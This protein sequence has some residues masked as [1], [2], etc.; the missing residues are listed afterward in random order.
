MK[1]VVL[2][3]GAANPGDLSWSLFERFGEVTAYS[4]TS[5]EVL[6][7]RAKDADICLTNKT[8][9][10]EEVISELPNLKYIGVLA[11]GYNVVDTEAAHRRNIVVTNVPEYATFATAQMTVALLLEMVNHTGLH[12]SS[13]MNGDWV[14]SE[15]FC[16]W[17]QP[18]TELWNKTV[19]IIGLGK[20]GCRVADTL[21]CLGMKVIGVGHNSNKA[22]PDFKYPILAFDEA[23][24]KADFISL[25]CPLND[26]SKNLINKNTIAQMKDGVR[27]INTARGPI[28]NE[29]DIFDALV[30]G[31]LAGYAADVIA[32][33]PMT[34]DCVL[35]KAPNCIITP[36]TAWAPLETRARLLNEAY[37]NLEAFVNGNPINAV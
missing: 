7:E 20:I 23:V 21:S 34:A 16:Y 27:I 25:H 1:I 30:S 12:S 17:K 18:L 4:Y 31:K 10:T 29:N 26:S 3:A 13:V 6:I 15:Q 32:K 28:V 36:H 2:D 24:S 5:P 9:F 14:K 8:C 19:C 33:E 35:I 11:T 22:Y 37:K